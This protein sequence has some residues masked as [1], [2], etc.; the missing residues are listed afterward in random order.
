MLRDATVAA[1]RLWCTVDAYRALTAL[2]AWQKAAY[3]VEAPPSSSGALRFLLLPPCPM[4]FMCWRCR[5]LL[6]FVGWLVSI[7]C[8]LG[9]CRGG[10]Q[11]AATKSGRPPA[12][13]PTRL[14]SRLSCPIV[15]FAQHTKQHNGAR[16]RVAR[17]RMARRGDVS[18][19]WKRERSRDP[20]TQDAKKESEKDSPV[21]ATH[22]IHKTK[23]LRGHRQGPPPP[24]PRPAA[25]PQQGQVSATEANRRARR[26]RSAVVK[27]SLSTP[28]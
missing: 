25:I 7:V 13:C 18:L 8:S 24:Q 10:R 4:A 15:S 3:E 17:H 21:R 20:E 2:A 27:R 19:D 26:R 12:E 14:S 6:R 11:R 1:R 9:A 5:R 16:T 22:P 23:Q 28:Q